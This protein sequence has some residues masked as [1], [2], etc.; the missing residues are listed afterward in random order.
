MLSNI[1]SIALREARLLWTDS[2]T[3]SVVLVAPFVYALLFC[4]VYS[5]HSLNELPIGV[6]VEDTS[7][8]A[9]TLLRMMDASPKLRVARTAYSM[10]EVKDLIYDN[11][12]SG[13]VVIP[14]DFTSRLKRGHDAH[15]VAYVNAASMVS[16]NTVAK[17][18]NETVM[19][20]SAGVEL[21]TLMKKGERFDNAKEKWMPVKLELRSLFNPSFNYSNFM[22]PGLLMAILQQVVLM[23]L[24]LCWTGE[25]ER[26]TLGELF[27]LSRKPWEL[28]IG[29]MIPYLVLNFL[30]AEFYLRVLFPLNDIPMEG[31]WAIAIPFT[32]LFILTLVTWGMW[33]G[34]IFQTRLFATQ[35]LMFLAM[36]SF[37][38]SGFTW[39]AEGMPT[40][41]RWMGQLLPMTHFVSSFRAV[42]LGGAPFYY[43]AHDFGILMG[44]C[45]LNIALAYYVVK[46]M[47]N[48]GAY[49]PS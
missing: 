3:R 47:I 48:S 39:P 18:L 46:R 49:P 17:A 31:S 13:A 36:P 41:I 23:G 16:A 5:N 8:S 45:A 15:V 11:A 12:I 34:A 19:T 26:G 21:R 33:M 27:L 30:I 24:A 38:L 1:L 7:T 40:V 2:R 32:F 44:F 4:A 6:I 9:R 20:F 29:K 10:E 37:I 43:V 14:R 42:Y 35:A 28:V 22:V 25:K